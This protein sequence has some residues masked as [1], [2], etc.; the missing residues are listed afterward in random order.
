L[1]RPKGK[2]S[3]LVHGIGGVPGHPRGLT[4]PGANRHPCPEPFVL[5]VS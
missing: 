4:A 1:D 2:F 5:P 3:S